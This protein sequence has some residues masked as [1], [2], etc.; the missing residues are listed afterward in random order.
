MLNGKAIFTCTKTICYSLIASNHHLNAIFCFKKPKITELLNM[1][2][3]QHELKDESLQTLGEHEL[4]LGYFMIFHFIIGYFHRLIRLLG[5]TKLIRKHINQSSSRG[6]ISLRSQSFQVYMIKY[7]YATSSW[8]RC[9]SLDIAFFTM[10]STRCFENPKTSPISTSLFGWPSSKPYLSLTIRFS[11][12]LSVFKSSSMCCLMN[13]FSTLTL[14][15]SFHISGTLS[16]EN[17]E[18]GYINTHTHTHSTLRSLHFLKLT[19]HL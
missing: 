12:G 5:I 7:L 14:G 9:L 16:C 2:H 11:M 13:S 3:G 8:L 10:K 15:G 1:H 19:F 18:D 17:K 6:N 4:M